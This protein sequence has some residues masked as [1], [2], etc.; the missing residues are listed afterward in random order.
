MSDMVAGSKSASTDILAL[1]STDRNWERGPSG[2]ADLQGFQQNWVT[3]PS[4]FV[5]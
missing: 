1:Y 2:V 4:F 5:R 3:A